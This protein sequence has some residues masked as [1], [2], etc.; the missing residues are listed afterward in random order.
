MDNPIL[1]APTRQTALDELLAR[2]HFTPETEYVP[3]ADCIDRVAA[4][5]IASVNT[6]PAKRV[7]AMDGYAVHSASFAH[8]RPE[9]SAWKAGADFT[10]ADTGDDFPDEYDTVIAVEQLHYDHDGKLTLTDDFVFRAGGG[11]RPAGSLL[12]RGDLL[13]RGNTRITPELQANLA[14]GG[15]MSVPVFRRPVVAFIPTGSELVPPGTEPQRG[16][17]IECNSLLISAYLRR[18]GAEPLCFPIV[19]DDPEQLSRCLE[20]AL[21]RADIVI[22]NGGSSKGTEDFSS[23]LLEPRASYFSH[24]VRTV[25]GRPVAIAILDEKPVIN[26]PGPTMAAWVVSDWLLY[27]M[28]CHYYGLPTAKRPCV[29]AFLTDALRKGP[30]VELYSKVRLEKRGELYYATPLGRDVRGSAV[31]LD[32][33]GLITAPIGSRGF[34]KGQPVT[35]ELLVDESQL[36]CCDEPPHIQLPT[37]CSQCENH[38]PAEALR[39][40]RGQA[41]FT[42][43]K[44]GEHFHSDSEAANALVEL[45]QAVSHM[46]RIRQLHGGSTADLLNALDESEQAQLLAL[47]Q[48]QQARFHADHAKRHASAAGKHD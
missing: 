8:G 6:I 32:G 13:V 9:V 24:G 34:E 1:R 20:E 23:R 28:L 43:L 44:S 16:Q 15:I 30:P 26:L 7:S 29:T 22:L 37:H 10:P 41:Y 27:P 40:G 33:L 35:V 4:E 2:W 12:Q 39:C 14:M 36:T 46:G 45:A 19:R 5:D 3:L 17:N 18:W 25:P 31:L 38:C 47:L 42:R 21:R 11:I 48:K